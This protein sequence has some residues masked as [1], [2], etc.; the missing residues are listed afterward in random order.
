MKISWFGHVESI[1][2][3]A[4]I[5]AI[6]V[7]CIIAFFI[8]V[9]L[10][11][12]NVHPFTETE[13]GFIGAKILTQG[14]GSLAER[15]F[16]KGYLII[17]TYMIF[18]L[19]N[20]EGTEIVGLSAAE[21]KDPEKSIPSACK[22]VTIEIVLIY[23]I[24]LVMLILI[25][26]YSKA[27]LD[28]SIF[29]YVLTA[30]GL[31]WAGHLFTA[32]TLVAAFSC[33]NSGLYGTTRAIYGLSLEGLAPEFLSKLNKNSVPMNATIFTLIWTWLV[34]L[35]G[36]LADSLHAFGDKGT[37]F[38]G[39]LL[40]ISGFTGTVMWVGI[41]ISQLVFRFKLKKRGYDA[42]KDII[43]K[44]FFYPYLHIFSAI[45]QI[46]AMILLIISPDG[47]VI[48]AISAVFFVLCMLVYWVFNKAGK[49][50]KDIKYDSSEI[51][52]DKK[53][54]PILDGQQCELDSD[55]STERIAP[56]L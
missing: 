6:G 53:Y 28:E 44:S 12:K 7:F 55:E 29:S 14:E 20:F 39:S 52:F 16:P 3:I 9:G 36:F 48:F 22:K 38:Y 46:L 34:L 51:Q 42:K 30:Y 23:I 10:I 47:W 43:S 41:I 50:R 49:V 37:S 13:V 35:F 45:V 5:A 11:G 33:G 25:V 17:I 26:P 8:W 21:T 31:K 2:S 32:V 4:K 24:P 40:G 18:V 19:V 27:S 56:E 54:P 15:L 1:M